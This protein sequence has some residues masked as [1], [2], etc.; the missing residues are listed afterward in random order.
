MSIYDDMFDLDDYFKR[1]VKK[2]R[3]DAKQYP[4]RLSAAL[5]FKKAW[6]RVSQSHADME[7]AEM[8]TIPVM[9]AIGTILNQFEVQR[10]FEDG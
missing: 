6:H 1:Q 7:R 5:G 10:G 4:E 8:K 2:A 9:A 3:V